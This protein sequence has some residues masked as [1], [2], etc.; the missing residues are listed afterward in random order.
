MESGR[1]EMKTIGRT[2][3]TTAS[4]SKV[5]RVSVSLGSKQGDPG[6]HETA[7]MLAEAALCMA[8]QLDKCTSLC[9][10]CSPAAGIG[11]VLKERLADKGFFFNVDT[12]EED[13]Q[14]E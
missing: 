8:L 14:P 5:L 9:G 10:V 3:P 13:F 6:Y 12:A 7:K 4:G 1:F 11:M 2:S